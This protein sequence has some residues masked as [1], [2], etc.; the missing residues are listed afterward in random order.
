[1][2]FYHDEEQKRLAEEYKTKLDAAHI[3]DKPLVTEIVRFGEFWPAEEYHHDYYRRNPG[4]G[5]CSLVITPK[6]EK[7]RKVFKDKVK[8]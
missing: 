8:Q 4:K 7:F 2:V 1:V 6:V 3:W 5:Y